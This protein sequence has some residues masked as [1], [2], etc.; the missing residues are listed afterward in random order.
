MKNVIVITGAAG[1]FGVLATRALAGHTMYTSMHET[2][3]RTA[4]QVERA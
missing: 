1:C 3:G 2:I 4:P